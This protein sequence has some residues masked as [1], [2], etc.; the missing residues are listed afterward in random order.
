VHLTINQYSNQL[1]A[2][3]YEQSKASLLQ[4]YLTT[5][6]PLQI[7]L[8]NP[9]RESIATSSVKITSTEE[10]ASETDTQPL[11]NCYPLHCA[12]KQRLFGKGRYVRLQ[13][14]ENCSA[15][16]STTEDRL[17]ECSTRL[18]SATLPVVMV[19]DCSDRH[20]LHTDIIEMNEEE[21]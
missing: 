8:S 1:E 20:R 7:D 17:S 13:E 18:T 21:E 4:H 16:H 2:R 9:S 19:T 6:N 11:D 10:I 5:Y 12:N 15:M 14:L 3:Q